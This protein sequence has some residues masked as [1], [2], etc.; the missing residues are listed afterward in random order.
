MAVRKKLYEDTGGM[1]DNLPMAYN[2]IDFCLK[3]M[4]SGYYNVYT[5]YAILYHYESK[6]KEYDTEEKEQRLK[7]EL[8]CLTNNWGQ[9]LESDFAYN[10]NLSKVPGSLF[11]IKLPE[12]FI[13]VITL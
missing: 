2:D 13:S 6:T 8:N 4:K 11:S 9:T 5:P 1:D 7:K 3:I 10:I 12:E